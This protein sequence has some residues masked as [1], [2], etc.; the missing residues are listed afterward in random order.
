MLVLVWRWPPKMFIVSGVY[1]RIRI[2]PLHLPASSVQSPCNLR[3]EKLSNC[4]MPWWMPLGWSR[5]RA[6]KKQ[7]CDSEFTKWHDIYTPKKCGDGWMQNTTA[8]QWL[9]YEWFHLVWLYVHGGP[10]IGI[11]HNHLASKQLHSLVPWGRLRRIRPQRQFSW[12][13]LTDSHNSNRAT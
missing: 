9:C 10:S 2:L 13:N 12:V 7:R 8:F 6:S 4:Q 1:Y 3:I 11:F 5:W